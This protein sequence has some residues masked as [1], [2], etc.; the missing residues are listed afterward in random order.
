V[1]TCRNVSLRFAGSVELN[2]TDPAG[3]T[4]EVRRT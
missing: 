3:N 1:L 2:G 4:V